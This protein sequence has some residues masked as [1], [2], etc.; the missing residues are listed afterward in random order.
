MRQEVRKD[1]WNGN[2]KHLYGDLATISPTIIVKQTT[3]IFKN[4][5]ICTPLARY[6]ETAKG[7]SEITVGE[8]VVKSPYE[9]SPTPLH[10][11]TQEGFISVQNNGKGVPVVVHKDWEG[12][13]ANGQFA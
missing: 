11:L 6:R 4:T 7:F 13:K 12:R 5:V 3:F 8:F 9:A 2:C 10:A 1:P